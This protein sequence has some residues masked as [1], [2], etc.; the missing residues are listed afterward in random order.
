MLICQQPQTAQLSTDKKSSLICAKNTQQETSFSSTQPAAG[1]RQEAVGTHF[2]V[3]A[4]VKFKPMKPH[5]N[6]CWF[7]EYLSA[8]LFATFIIYEGQ[9]LFH[10]LEKLQNS[11]VPSSVRINHIHDGGGGDGP[12]GGKRFPP[13]RVVFRILPFLGS[14]TVC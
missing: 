14:P 12:C 4:V 2:P 9:F 6:T 5:T 8:C 10:L 3:A 1:N 7:V 11:S 13:A